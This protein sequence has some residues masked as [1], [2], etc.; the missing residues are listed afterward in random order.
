MMLQGSGGH[1]F[2]SGFTV[3]TFSGVFGGGIY[4]PPV[5]GH[6]LG[7]LGPS[8]LTAPK[9]GGHSVFGSR[10]LFLLSTS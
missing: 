3:L 7:T 1:G 5:P 9:G 8:N 4:D 6:L 2:P 10:G